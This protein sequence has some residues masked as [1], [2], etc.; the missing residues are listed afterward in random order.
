MDLG[1]PGDPGTDSLRIRRED[2][3]DVERGKEKER[4]ELRGH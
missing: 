4:K 2:C 3:T 1:I